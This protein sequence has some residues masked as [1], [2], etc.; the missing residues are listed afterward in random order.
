M[1]EPLIVRAKYTLVDEAT[2]VGDVALLVKGDRIAEVVSA[3]A[4]PVGARVIDCGD[5][6]LMPAPVNA[7]THLELTHLGRVAP[8]GGFLRWGVRVALRR[9]PFNR[10]RSRRGVRTGIRR[11]VEA[12]T[13]FVADISTLHESAEVLARD[14]LPSRSFLEVMEPRASLADRKLA[15]LAKRLDAFGD[16]GIDPSLLGI[17]PHAPYS[18]SAPLA[19]GLARLAE[20]RDLPLSIHLAELREEAAFLADGS[21]PLGRFLRR[22]GLLDRDWKPPGVTPVQWARDAG[23]LSPRTLA[24]HVNFVTDDDV[25]I[26]AGSGATAVLCPRS[27]SHFGHDATPAGHHAHR[28][29]DAG[30]PVVLGTDSLASCPTLSMID[31]MRFLRRSCD[32]LSDADILRTG[33]GRDLPSAVSVARRGRLD[34]SFRADIIALHCGEQDLARVGRS[35]LAGNLPLVFAM[36]GGQVAH[37]KDTEDRR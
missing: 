35:V 37:M 8:R 5:A 18:V 16:A 6:V 14:E 30:V 9:M 1:A 13:A 34:A 36:T 12:G 11:C 33:L 15:G 26:L 23:L 28:L 27:R 2:C 17:A 32:E 10:R 21:G 3:G 4:V 22:F 24:V 31:E 20:E 7:H 29:L 19:R 25:R